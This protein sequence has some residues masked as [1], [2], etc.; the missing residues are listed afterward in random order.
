M[1]GFLA[2]I[3]AAKKTKVVPKLKA[4]IRK[5]PLPPVI[6]MDLQSLFSDVT[7]K[8][9]DSEKKLADRQQKDAIAAQ[10]DTDSQTADSVRDTSIDAMVTELNSRKTNGGATVMLQSS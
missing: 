3:Y 10:A 1:A 4:L 2:S 6:F 8:I 7:A 5:F 9:D